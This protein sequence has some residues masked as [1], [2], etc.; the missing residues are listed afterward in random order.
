MPMAFHMNVTSLHTSSDIPW[1]SQ[2]I[3]SS[4]HARDL[5][6]RYHQIPP[7]NVK[8]KGLKFPIT[9][10]LELHWKNDVSGNMRELRRKHSDISFGKGLEGDIK[11]RIEDIELD[12]EEQF[13]LVDLK[14]GKEDSN[15]RHPSSI[16]DGVIDGHFWLIF[17][18]VI[19]CRNLPMLAK[20]RTFLN[21]F[22]Y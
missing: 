7:A 5:I 17:C 13:L 15:R 6:C 11:L 18:K 20:P 16:D 9:V 19:L 10:L 22:K 4:R 2:H 21:S 1:L 12:K 8:L 3:D 14:L